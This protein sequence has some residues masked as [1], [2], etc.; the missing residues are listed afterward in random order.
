MRVFPGALEHR[1]KCAW[2]HGIPMGRWGG[3]QGTYI[4][5]LTEARS[6]NK[7]SRFEY[8]SKASQWG[9]G[10]TFREI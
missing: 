5:L 8:V 10:E 2:L 1:S 9:D 3:L 4:S 6:I 7:E